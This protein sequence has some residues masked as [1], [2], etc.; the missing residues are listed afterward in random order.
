MPTTLVHHQALQSAM[1]N[2]CDSRLTTLTTTDYITHL[3]R[4]VYQAGREKGREKTDHQLDELSIAYIMNIQQIQ[5]PFYMTVHF[6]HVSHQSYGTMRQ[7][8]S[9]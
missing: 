1:L 7:T 2:V 4:A 6:Q 3:Q 5:R 8:M 9:L